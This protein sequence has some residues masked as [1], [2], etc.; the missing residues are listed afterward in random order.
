M[1]N[2][3]LYFLKFCAI[4]YLLTENG[5]IRM[6]KVLVI[7]EYHTSLL[8]AL[9][10]AKK[11]GIISDYTSYSDYLNKP[12]TSH[13]GLP[14]AIYTR[15]IDWIMSQVTDTFCDEY[16]VMK[17][18][19]HS[20]DFLRTVIEINKQFTKEKVFLSHCAVLQKERTK[21]ILTDAAFNTQ[22]T[23]ENQ[24]D[25][26]NNAIK[27]YYD[28]TKRKEEPIVNYVLAECNYKIPNF[29]LSESF[30]SNILPAQLDTALDPQRNKLKNSAETKKADIIIVPDINMGNAIWKSLTVLGSFTVSGFVVGTKFTCLLNSRG[31]SEDSYYKSLLLGSKL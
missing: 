29:E 2:F 13:S 7:G 3:W 16:I 24:M 11:D 5:E 22:L 21:F 23:R 28:L 8:N 15:E 30:P 19:I 12:E 1:E 31:D 4:L 18:K 17:G 10:K 26:Y 20:N 27:F 25:I 6:K 14:D 9:K